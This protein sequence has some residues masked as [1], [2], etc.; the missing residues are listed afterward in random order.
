MREGFPRR[1]GAAGRCPFCDVSFRIPHD[2]RPRRYRDDPLDDYEDD[3]GHRRHRAPATIWPAFGGTLL[4][5]TF[6]IFLS[7]LFGALAQAH[8]FP[9]LMWL[10]GLAGAV[11]GSVLA[12]MGFTVLAGRGDTRKGLGGGMIGGGVGGTFLGATVAYSL[13]FVGLFI[14]SCSGAFHQRDPR[15]REAEMRKAEAELQ[16]QALIVFA[17]FVLGGTVAGGF[18]GLLGTVWGRAIL[19]DR[20]PLDDPYDGSRRRNRS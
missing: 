5:G 19:R 9:L 14:A 12:T 11:A 7:Y 3:L 2:D 4:A 6:G 16:R 17:A 1:P 15:A 10:L 18:G 8:A 20:P 13:L